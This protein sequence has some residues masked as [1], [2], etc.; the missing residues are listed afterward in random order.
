MDQEQL[1][2]TTPRSFAEAYIQNFER[3]AGRFDFRPDDPETLKKR[4]RWL[5]ETNGTRADRTALMRRLCK[6]NENM[7]NSEEAIGH[8]RLLG[9]QE[10]LVMI[11]GQQAG[12]FSGPLLVL[13]KAVTL[14][15]AAHS[16][17]RELGRPVIPVFWIAGEDHDFDEVNHTYVLAHDDT[18]GKIQIT[19]PKGPRS[20]VSMLRISPDQWIQA[21]AVLESI[22]PDAVH[23]PVI[24]AQLK[25]MSGKSE[26]LSEMFARM[27]A[28]LF[29]KYGLVLMDAADPELRR[30]EQGMFAALIEHNSQLAQ[31][32]M[33]GRQQVELL[34]FPPQVEASDDA[35]HLFLIDRGERRLLMRQGETFADKGERIRYGKDQLLQLLE[36]DPAVFSNNVCT[37]PL[38]QDYLFPVLGTVL[39]PGEI[40][41]W[42]MLKEAFHTFGM[43]MPIVLPRAEYTLVD[44]R[45]R[46]YMS[47]FGLHF[48][49]VAF[50]LPTLK[51]AWITGR[52]PW[53][54]EA[55]FT[56]VKE[57]IADIYESLLPDLST[58]QP[59]L[60]RLGLTNRNKLFE[61]VDYLRR[62]VEWTIEDRH[63]ASIRQWD[64]LEKTVLPFGKKQERVYNGWMYINRFGIDWVDRLVGEPSPDGLF[65]QVSFHQVI[66]L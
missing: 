6:Y 18:I 59:E 11:G 12:L 57:R 29:G 15:R 32:V 51:D 39:G 34:G 43:R 52:Q 38:M 10:T 25:R 26:T 55:R 22:L 46:K 63:T 1:M 8:I 36:R 30:L 9:H 20:S 61:Q 40:A 16:A 13:Y 41:Y 65:H 48:R 47:A 4:S 31:A 37:R 64:I 62:R 42:G 66:Y 49:D 33:Q 19:R 45:I 17:S 23:K 53:P 56:E 35:A 5:D 7:G 60:A 3:V 50:S 14:I 27:M 21:I 28:C 58:V 24:M 54:V 44:E 2:W